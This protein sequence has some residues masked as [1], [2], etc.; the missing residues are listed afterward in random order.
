MIDLNKT[1]H[2]RTFLGT[3]GATAAAM[4]AASLAS[5]TKSFGVIQ[6]AAKPSADAGFDSWLGKIQGKHKQVF[7]SPEPKGGMPLAWT[8]VFQMT[9]ASVG[10]AEGDVTA[11]LILRH[12]SIPLGMGHDM[13][14]KYKFGENFK[15]DDGTTKAPALR[16]PFYQPKEGELPLPGMSIDDLLKS[17]VLVGIC[18]MAMTF[19]SSKVFA[20]KFN[21]DGAAIKKDWVASVLPGIQI[22]PSG[23]LAVNRAQ[24]HG[25][26]YCFA[27]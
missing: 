3:V 19:Y 22:V 9:N 23:V 21:M 6:Q 2:R 26:T 27:G 10:V 7:D 14:T 16:N 25:C 8:R 11:V 20:P 4:G 17:G 15:I 5:V 18:D 13:W 24:E 12:E 1:T